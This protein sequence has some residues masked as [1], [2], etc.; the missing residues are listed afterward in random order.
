MLKM[1]SRAEPGQM[2]QA[3]RANEALKTQLAQ[4]DAAA[5]GPAAAAQAARAASETAAAARR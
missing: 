2:S 5:K 4:D 1:R 3:D